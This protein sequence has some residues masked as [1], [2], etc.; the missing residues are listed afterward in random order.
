MESLVDAILEQYGMTWEL[1][2]YRIVDKRTGQVVQAGPQFDVTR[3]TLQQQRTTL[4]KRYESR[5]KRSD[6]YTK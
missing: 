3:P 5:F 1:D 2:P 4:D 6:D